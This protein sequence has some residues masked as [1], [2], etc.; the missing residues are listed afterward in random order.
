MTLFYLN[1]N[2]TDTDHF[3]K[4]PKGVTKDPSPGKGCKATSWKNKGIAWASDKDKKFI[5]LSKSDASKAVLDSVAV[6]STP[7]AGSTIMM[8]YANFKYY[9]CSDGS[10]PKTCPYDKRYADV[11]NEEFIVW[12]RTSG[13]P[14]FRKLHRIIDTDLKEG[15]IVHFAINNVFPVSDFSGTKAIVLS[16]TEW[17]GGKNKFLG[18]AYIVVAIVCILLAIGFLVKQM[19]SPRAVAN[20]KELE[21]SAHAGGS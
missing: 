1:Q 3:Y 7:T 14:N 15:E 13:L 20:A 10:D 9:K 19:H 2:G 5:A 16:T 8:P 11:N 6:D 12:M 18:W 4:C 17:I 21:E